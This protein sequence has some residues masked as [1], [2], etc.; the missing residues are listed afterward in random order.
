VHPASRAA[1]PRLH[2]DR[3]VRVDGAA[4]LGTRGARSACRQR[5]GA[6][7]VAT[8]RSDFPNQINNVLA[9]P[10]MF[11][12]ALDSGAARVT[13]EMKRAAALA[14]ADLVVDDLA[15]DYVVPSV[16]DPRVAPAV[17]EAVASR[18]THEAS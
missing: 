10:G 8:G 11:R 1:Q 18:V 3:P 13:E 9:L 7:V 2:A 15:A 5:A 17:A 12:G 6:A 4:R 16:F 14:I